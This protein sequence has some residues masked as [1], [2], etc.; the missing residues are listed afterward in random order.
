M[1]GGFFY[2]THLWWHL[3]AKFSHSFSCSNESSQFFK[4]KRSRLTKFIAVSNQHISQRQRVQCCPCLHIYQ[5]QLQLNP[6][7]ERKKQRG[8]RHFSWVD[9][10]NSLFIK[11]SKQTQKPNWWRKLFFWT[12]NIWIRIQFPQLF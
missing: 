9:I 7:L 1:I 12:D 5:E 4:T 6:T 3:L 10:F 2:R 8:S 11:R